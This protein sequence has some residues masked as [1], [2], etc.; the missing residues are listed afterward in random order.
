[1]AETLII[2]LASADAPEP[3]APPW[4]WLQCNRD[5]RVIDEGRGK[6]P[7]AGDARVVALADMADC[8]CLTASL[9]ELS[10][11]RLHQALPYALEDRLAGGID[12]QHVTGAGRD[13]AGDVRALVIERA[14]LEAYLKTLNEAGVEPDALVPDALCLPWRKGE[15][16]VMA[17]DTR[18]L[19]RWGDWQAASLEPALFDSLLPELVFDRIRCFGERPAGLG[20]LDLAVERSPGGIGVLAPRAMAM[21]GQL[22]T[23]EF[24]PA[25]SSR[26]HRRWLWAA[27]LAGALIVSQFLLAGVE[28]LQLRGQARTLGDEV[29]AHFSQ[30]FPGVA[31]VAGRERMLAERELARLRFG[32]EAGFMDLLAAVAPVV[33]G[34]EQA[35]VQSL[36]YRDSALE[37]RLRA[38]SIAELD[39]LERRLGDAGVNARVESVSQSG[40]AADGRVI[41]Q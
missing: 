37:I 12:E 24:A 21:T 34:T 8:L 41:I 30:A 29:A 26:H 23:G 19:A 28:Y 15:L 14:R 16:S 7:S 5:G 17:T 4:R 22:L 25:T 31:P 40:D 11:R 20:H 33:E 10:G 1:M 2:H 38:A 3:G 27:G 32:E 13:G 18:V 9:P 36:D 35:Q 6:P 39:R